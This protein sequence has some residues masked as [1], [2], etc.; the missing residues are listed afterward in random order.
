MVSGSRA[1]RACIAAMGLLI[2]IGTPYGRATAADDGAICI[3]ET[4]DVAIAACTRA[5]KSGKHK[6]H[7][8]AL[9]Y[10]NRGVEWKLK[11]DYEHALA[12]YSEAI[13]IDAKYAD[14]FYNRC[15]TY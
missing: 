11:K 3:N 12:D 9:Q 5:I 2:L 4:G 15:A 14:A 1:S 10:N 8:L 6:G 7:S 13:R